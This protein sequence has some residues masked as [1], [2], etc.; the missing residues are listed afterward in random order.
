MPCDNATT[1]SDLMGKL[2]VLRVAC[3]KCGGYGKSLLA[4]LTCGIVCYLS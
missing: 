2:D 4:R 1:F 3:D